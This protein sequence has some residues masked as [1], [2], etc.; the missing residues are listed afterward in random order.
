M[1]ISELACLFGDDA[2][3]A[4]ITG[5]VD[6]VRVKVADLGE[7]SLKVRIGLRVRFFRDDLAA[8][9]CKFFFKKLCEALAVIRVDIAEDGGRFCLAAC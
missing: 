5:N 2:D 4:V 1:F 3:L 7:L 6:D 9:A 8:E